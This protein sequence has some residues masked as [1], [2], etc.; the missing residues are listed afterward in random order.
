VEPST[1]S[2]RGHGDLAPRFVPQPF[3]KLYLYLIELVFFYML[4]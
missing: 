4:R 1:A 3:L 2:G